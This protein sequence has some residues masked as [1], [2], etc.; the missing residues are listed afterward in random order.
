MDRISTN[1][2]NDNMQFFMRERQRL[3]E[4]TQNQIASQ[5]RIQN[6]RD[7]PLAASHAT[8]YRSY[9][10]RLE[11]FSD[12]I[13][14]VQERNRIAEGHVQRATD[15]LQRA[16]ELAV[17]GA[18]GTY[19]PEDLQHM[20][21][22]V[23]EIIN[24]MV[25]IANARDSDGTTIFSGDRSQQLPF[26]A[27][28][29]FAPVRAVTPLPRFSIGERSILRQRRSV[30]TPTSAPISPATRS[31]GRRTSRSSRERTP[32]TTR[33]TPRG[34][35]PS[36]ESKSPSVKATTYSRSFSGSM[37]R[38]LPYGL[39]SIRSTPVSSFRGPRPTRS[40]SR[41]SR[42]VRFFRTLG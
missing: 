18:H 26:R 17:Q 39:V 14:T 42:G 19:A 6:L 28:R 24:E 10:V 8:R 29:A 3:M 34:R 22:E 27:L 25:E 37:S 12:N 5:S 30:K 1:L 15:L 21:T 16:R 38:G 23:N 20:A 41:T 40:G 32:G 7:D 35:S 4:Q 36:T 13:Q 33:S 31:S 11:R 9:T 2:P